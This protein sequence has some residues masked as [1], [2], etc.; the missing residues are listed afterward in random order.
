[1]QQD[2]G[3]QKSNR[4]SVQ[5]LIYPA[6]DYPAVQMQP[7]EVKLELTRANLGFYEGLIDLAQGMTFP[8]FEIVLE[9]TN[10]SQSSTVNLTVS[11]AIRK[12]LAKIYETDRILFYVDIL[13]GKMEAWSADMLESIRILGELGVMSPA[14]QWILNA[15]AY[16]SN[17]ITG[18]TGDKPRSYDGDKAIEFLREVL[19]A[20]GMIAKIDSDSK[21]L[22]IASDVVRSGKKDFDSCI[23]RLAMAFYHSKNYSGRSVTP[24]IDD[25]G[26]AYLGITGS[27]SLQAKFPKLMESI[28]RWPTE[29]RTDI[30]K[31]F[32]CFCLAGYLCHTATRELPR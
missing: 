20:A 2:E 26:A 12:Q 8:F 21:L 11:P 17:M 6:T 7:K 15:R 3:R 28:S 31:T 32:I 19:G 27:S 24:E 5:V 4:L 18:T 16:I 14:T 22:T 10:K 13:G 9:E 1:M 25:P 29:R 30:T 23:Y